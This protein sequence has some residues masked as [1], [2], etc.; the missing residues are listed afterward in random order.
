V[1]RGPSATAQ[2]LQEEEESQK[3][4]VFDEAYSRAQAD[5]DLRKKL[6]DWLVITRRN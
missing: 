1:E 2:C 4:K 6:G 5:K 3:A